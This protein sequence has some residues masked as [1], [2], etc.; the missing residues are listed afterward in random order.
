MAILAFN[1]RPGH[2]VEAE[3]LRRYG[4]AVNGDPASKAKAFF[5]VLSVGRCKFRLSVTLVEH[6]LQAI[7]GGFPKAFQV[8]QLDDRVF[9]FSMA[10]QLVSFHIFNL[11]SFECVDFKVFFHLWHGGGPNYQLNIITSVW[12]R[13]LNGRQRVN[14]RWYVSLVLTLFQS[15]ASVVYLRAP[16]P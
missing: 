6:L 7:L 14:A 11:R 4:S 8:V 3:I 12:S 15:M 2:V 16:T 13:I 10:S 1:T 9:R 5:L